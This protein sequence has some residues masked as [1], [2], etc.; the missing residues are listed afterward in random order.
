MNGDNVKLVE[1]SGTKKK[2]YIEEKINELAINRT[3]I[4]RD[5]CRSITQI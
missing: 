2:E 5:M 1:L 3:G 4:L